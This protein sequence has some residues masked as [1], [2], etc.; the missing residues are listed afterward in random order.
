MRNGWQMTRRDS[1]R[2]ASRL[3]HAK[4]AGVTEGPDGPLGVLTSEL[5][6]SE[7]L[8]LAQ[9][10]RC[11]R[12]LMRVASSILTDHH[13]VDDFGEMVGVWRDQ[14]QSFENARERR[15]GRRAAREPN[16]QVLLLPHRPASRGR[17]L[18]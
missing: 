8:P 15:S 13:E 17:G 6:W 11:L 18:G 3:V 2:L 10:R 16:G 5:P 4:L 12:D 9:R 1:L 14:A 7:A